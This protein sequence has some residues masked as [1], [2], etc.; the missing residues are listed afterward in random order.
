MPVTAWIHVGDR[1]KWGLLY[2]GLRPITRSPNDT[3]LQLSEQLYQASPQL[4]R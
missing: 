3:L 4:A 1:Q 2:V